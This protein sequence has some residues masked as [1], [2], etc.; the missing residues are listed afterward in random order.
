MFIY[1]INGQG[2]IRKKF[3]SAHGSGESE[4]FYK[5]D[6]NVR[7]NRVKS[8]W[9]WKSALHTKG[10]YRRKPKLPVINEQNS[11]KGDLVDSN[12]EKNNQKNP[13]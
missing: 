10:V 6:Q 9:L 11:S 12:K 13:N 8:K 2:N 1:N 4:G 7:E 5:A 3:I